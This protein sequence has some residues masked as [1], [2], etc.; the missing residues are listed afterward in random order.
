[1]QEMILGLVAPLQRGNGKG[2]IFVNIVEIDE[3]DDSVRLN[4]LL[5]RLAFLV[6]EVFAV[7]LQVAHLFLLL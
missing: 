3:L 1:M 4:V 7:V 6:S 2:S 5:V